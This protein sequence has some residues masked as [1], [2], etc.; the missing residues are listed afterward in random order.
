MDDMLFFFYGSFNRTDVFRLDGI[1]IEFLKTLEGRVVNFWSDEPRDYIIHHQRNRIIFRDVNDLNNILFFFFFPYSQITSQIRGVKPGLIA[2]EDLRAS[3]LNV[4][5]YNIEQKS[6]SSFHSFLNLF[7]NLDV[8]NGI[9]TRN[10]NLGSFENNPRGGSRFY[11]VIDDSVVNIGSK[12]ETRIINN[13]HFFPERSK[14]VQLSF[15]GIFLY[16]I[17]FE[18]VSEE[19][20]VVD[21]VAT[22]LLGNFPNPFNPYTTIRFSVAADMFRRGMPRPNTSVEIDALASHAF[23]HVSIDVFNI[24]GQRVRSLVSGYFSSGNHSVVWDG[25]DD[26]GVSVGSG[27]YF[28]RM[29]AGEFTETRRMLLVR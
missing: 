11:S 20:E 28:Y 14:M 7:S 24:R 6:L 23:T 19:V 16:D 17:E 8:C 1:E 25:R 4:Y 10:F 26:R 29:R 2:F 5:S 22:A 18:T 15:N 21:V 9:I 3:R 27:I 13:T 12:P